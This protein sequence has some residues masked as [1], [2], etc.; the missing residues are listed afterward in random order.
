MIRLYKIPKL[1]LEF[2]GYVALS[3]ILA[4]FS[5]AFLFYTSISLANKAVIEGKYPTSS[6]SEPQFI[7]WLQ[8]I[9]IIAGI[10]IFL[11]FLVYFLAGKISYIL[12]IK[13]AIESYKS[14]NL[15]SEIELIGEDELTD[16][17]DSF[18]SLLIALSNHTKNEEKQKLE[19]DELIRGLSHDIR[20]P[21]TS[22]ISYADFIKTKKY[23]CEEKLQSY[24]ELIQ[25]KATKID[26]LSK[27]MLDTPSNNKPSLLE[28]K[29]MFEQFISE[30]EDALESSGF[31]INTD[32]LG[33]INFKTVLDPQD[34]SRIFDNL[35]SNIIKYAD[36]KEK[37]TLKAFVKNNEIFL[38]Q[39]NS[40]NFHTSLNEESHGIGLKNIQKIVLRYHGEMDC[41]TTSTTYTFKVKLPFPL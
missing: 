1:A 27:A 5:S 29:V 8:L 37:I 30:F 2:I 16:L 18:N 19:K 10:I 6:I 34:I 20:T 9:C 13:E 31:S 15:T 14:G 41:F 38:I 22:I 23:D 36:K 7:A 28:G 24:A 11:A 17:A 26:E 12:T 33:L 25:L 3:L 32:T 39:S 40:I 21:L 4:A 35:Y